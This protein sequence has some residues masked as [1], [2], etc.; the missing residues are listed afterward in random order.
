MTGREFEFQSCLASA[1]RWR[2]QALYLRV[3]AGRAHLTPEQSAILLCQA[4]AADGQ[5]EWWIAGAED[6]ATPGEGARS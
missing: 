5:A 4:E 1:A 2:Q 6:Y 3:H